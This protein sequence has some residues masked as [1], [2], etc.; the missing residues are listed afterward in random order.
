MTVINW[1]AKEKVETAEHP[2]FLFLD[3]KKRSHPIKIE[4]RKI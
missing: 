4:M 1:G 3:G 2:F